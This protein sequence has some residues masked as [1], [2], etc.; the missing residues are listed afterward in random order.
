MG[1][2]L[3][4]PQSIIMDK[5]FKVISFDID[6]AKIFTKYA[7]YPAFTFIRRVARENTNDNGE[8]LSERSAEILVR[9]FKI[10]VI[11]VVKYLVLNQEL[12]TDSPYIIA[13][14]MPPSIVIKVWDLFFTYT[15]SYFAFCEAVFGKGKILVKQSKQMTSVEHERYLNFQ[16]QIQ[17]QKWPYKKYK[18]LPKI[19]PNFASLEQYSKEVDNKNVI[20]LTDPQISEAKDYFNKLLSD[21]SGASNYNNDYELLIMQSYLKGILK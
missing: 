11:G 5:A 14:F 2:I 3:S 6:N 8:K 13:P 1:G 18:G 10:Y 7:K 15:K 21:H 19:F 17:N 20:W 12:D 16:E 4:T 9:Q